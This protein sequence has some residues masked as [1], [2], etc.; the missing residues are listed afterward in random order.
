[1]EEVCFFG[2]ALSITSTSFDKKRFPLSI[3][4][5]P[6]NGKGRSLI[7]RVHA[8]NP[9]K[10]RME[11][12]TTAYHGK[13]FRKVSLFVSFF[14]TLNK[15][16]G[17]KRSDNPFRSANHPMIVMMTDRSKDHVLWNATRT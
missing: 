12:K 2:K 17:N 8:K 9:K 11:P 1:M 15:D 7:P 4:N 13:I 10:S 14:D 6:K 3:Q 5:D 16:V